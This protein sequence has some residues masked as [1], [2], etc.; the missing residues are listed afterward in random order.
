MICLNQIVPARFLVRV[1]TS[2]GGIFLVEFSSVA[3]GRDE[4]PDATGDG[5]K[6][7]S[8]EEGVVVAESGDGGR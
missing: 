4:H 6:D 1:Y 3:E 8:E 7:G 2:Q 5:E